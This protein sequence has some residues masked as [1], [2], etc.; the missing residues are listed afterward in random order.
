MWTLYCAP[1][2]NTHVP[3]PWRGEF[4]WYSQLM[5]VPPGP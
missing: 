1:F 4:I 2:E 3:A 5:C